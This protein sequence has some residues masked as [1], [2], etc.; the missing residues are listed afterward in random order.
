MLCTYASK[1]TL[2]RSMFFAIQEHHILTQLLPIDVCSLCLPFVLKHHFCRCC[3]QCECVC[4]ATWKLLAI[5]RC[6]RICTTLH[7]FYGDVGVC[8][9]RLLLLKIIWIKFISRLFPAFSLYVAMLAILYSNFRTI[10]LWSGNFLS[11]IIRNGCGYHPY[12]NHQKPFFA[13]IEMGDMRIC[14]M[15]GNNHNFL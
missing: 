10:T 1:Q 2:F 9:F 5:H 11:F 15:Y 14:Y 13:I 6:V 7:N 8:L 12:K 4:N 3:C